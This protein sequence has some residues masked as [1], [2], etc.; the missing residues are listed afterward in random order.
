M[1]PFGV[2]SCYSCPVFSVFRSVIMPCNPSG[3]IILIFL[4]FFLYE[5]EPLIQGCAVRGLSRE[6]G[7][8]QGFK[9]GSAQR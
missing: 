3:H 4:Y 6:T 9:D 1:G 5:H 8:A 2:K 7:M